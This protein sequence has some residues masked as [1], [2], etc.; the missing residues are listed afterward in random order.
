M[1]LPDLGPSQAMVSSTVEMT[2]YKVIFKYL[3]GSKYTEPT[4]ST[5]RD[6]AGR[7][8]ASGS[9]LGTALII[10]SAELAR[11]FSTGRPQ[12][13]LDAQSRGF[14][15]RRSRLSAASQTPQRTANP[16]DAWCLPR[17]LKTKQTHGR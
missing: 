1:K 10:L 2:S 12:G 15:E 7:A 13:W 8:K 5:F 9:S 4:A 3:G 14:R 6:R 17:K 11:A 16:G